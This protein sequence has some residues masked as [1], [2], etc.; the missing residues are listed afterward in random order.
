MSSDLGGSAGREI[1]WPDL[2]EFFASRPEIRRRGGAGRPLLGLEYEVLPVDP[3]TGRARPFL[4]PAGSSDG[5]VEAAFLGLLDCPGYEAPAGDGRPTMLLHGSAAVNLEPGGQFELTGS[6]VE[7]L[8]QAAEE[9][10]RM[11]ADFARAA[12]AQGF[13]FLTHGAQ[14][15]TLASEM[16]MVPKRRYRILAEH[17]AR[18]G[19]QR[20]LDMMMRT[21]SIQISFDYEDEADAG[22]KLR[23]ALLAAP[24]ATALFANSPFEEGRPCGLLC[25]RGA[26]W[27]ETDSARTGPVPPAM[28]GDWSFERYARWAAGI[29]SVLVRAEDGG[30]APAP[31]GDFAGLMDEGIHGRRPILADW[32]LQL[33]AIFTAV[34]L[35]RVIEIRCCDSTPPGTQMAGPA[36][37]TGLLYH[38][39]SLDGVLALMAPF[40]SDWY[41]LQWA[42]CL[43]GLQAQAGNAVSMRDLAVELVGLA[44]AG[45]LARGLGEERYLAPAEEWADSGRQ[46]ARQALEDFERGG[47]AAVLERD[48]L[49]EGPSV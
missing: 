29:P 35:K 31:A 22:R 18:H 42:A 49:P 21:G 30:V 1:D 28:D 33:S 9:L 5:S 6:P 7:D 12:A 27:R 47:L 19:G 17:L 25:S 23:A 43:D 13:V 11:T 14:P 32:E 8:H 16:E 10:E 4:G 15:V 46:P 38:P 3:A 24:V 26:V 40:G 39:A 44:R 2:V 20:Y 45:L 37:W 34:R 48:R 41:G 36:F